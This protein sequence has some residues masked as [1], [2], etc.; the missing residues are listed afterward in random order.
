V[1]GPWPGSRPT[2]GARIRAEEPVSDAAAVAAA[3]AA[4]ARRE[5]AR[6]ARRVR[7]V[8]DRG[9]RY[10]YLDDESALAGGAADHCRPSGCGA[11]AM[12]FAGTLPETGAQ[13]AGLAAMAGDPFGGG[14]ELP[15]VPGTWT[16]D[17]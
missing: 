4:A 9:Y 17:E 13:P 12:G 7:S 15:M 1:G 3:A 14:P 6:A 16:A 10:E 2:L 5:Q 8:I 11:G